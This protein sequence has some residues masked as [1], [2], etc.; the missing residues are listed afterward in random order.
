[1]NYKNLLTH[2]FLISEHHI[3]LKYFP[4]IISLE[5]FRLFFGAIIANLKVDGGTFC[6]LGNFKGK[7]PWVSGRRKSVEPKS[8]SKKSPSK[9]VGRA[10]IFFEKHKPSHRLYAG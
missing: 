9:S 3:I 5:K 10:K 8:Q 1:M 4:N 2:Y 6:L 7:H